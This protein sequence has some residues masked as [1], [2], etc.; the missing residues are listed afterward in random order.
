MK[1]E[2]LDELIAA[3]ASIKKALRSIDK[4]IMLATKTENTPIEPKVDT[5]KRLSKII[6]NKYDFTNGATRWVRCS[7]V[8]I[9]IGIPPNRGNSSAVG[10]VLEGMNLPLRRSNGQ[11]LRKIPCLKNDE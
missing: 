5:V 3:R 8:C 6:F 2:I 7:D 11:T 1:Q 9:E 10:T 4:E